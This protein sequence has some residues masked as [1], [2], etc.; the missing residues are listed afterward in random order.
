[1]V[2][3]NCT[4]QEL[5]LEKTLIKFKGVQY[6]NALPKQITKDCETSQLFKSS[7]K[8]YLLDNQCC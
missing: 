7:M 8:Q 3:T 5:N 4:N 2:V 6:W 1:M